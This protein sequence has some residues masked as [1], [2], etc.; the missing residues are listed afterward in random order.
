VN[1]CLIETNVV[2]E[3]VR[4]QP[5]PRVIGWLNRAD[6]ERLFSSVVTIWEIR[7]GIENLPMGK[8]RAELESWF[9]T[10]VPD[11]F[12]ANLLPITRPIADRWGRLSVGARRG[13]NVVAVAAGL[14][15]AT[16]VEHELVVVTRNVR[17]FGVCGVPIIHPRE[18]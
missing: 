2:S 10:G 12:G 18:I 15:A 1:G 7:L 11:W 8:R 6:Q 4:P 13:G 16:A 5:D 17:D 14:I 9:S 3:F